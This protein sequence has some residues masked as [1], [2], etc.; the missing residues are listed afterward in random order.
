MAWTKVCCRDGC[1][2]FDLDG[3]HVVICDD[4]ANPTSTLRLTVEEWE[5]LKKAVDS[6]I[7]SEKAKHDRIL[8]AFASAGR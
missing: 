1:P 5:A 3:D 6:T 2:S 7:A 4:E 8:K